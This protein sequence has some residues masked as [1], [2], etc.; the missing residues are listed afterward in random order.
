MSKALCDPHDPKTSLLQD[1]SVSSGMH[2]PGVR[3][4]QGRRD[5]FC[6]ADN[7]AAKVTRDIKDLQQQL[8]QLAKD[9]DAEAT[10]EESYS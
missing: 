2:M 7:Q 6:V 5:V 3:E 4:G 10:A 8:T 9:W 1:F